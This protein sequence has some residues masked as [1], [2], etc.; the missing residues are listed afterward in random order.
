[1]GWG[2]TTGPQTKNQGQGARDTTRESEDSGKGSRNQ[3]G[4]W[5]NFRAVDGAVSGTKHNI[6]VGPGIVVKTGPE[7][8]LLSNYGVEHGRVVGN[9][10][11]V[12]E[13]INKH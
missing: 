6:N 12:Q 11:Q 13:T 2:T 3:Q 8:V 4:A 7:L 10:E 9:K 1:M 5:G